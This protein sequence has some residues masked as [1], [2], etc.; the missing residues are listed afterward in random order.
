MSHLKPTKKTGFLDSKDLIKVTL[1]YAGLCLLLFAPALTRP[2]ASPDSISQAYPVYAYNRS[3][4]LDLK[5]LPFWYPHISG[6]T[7]YIE[8]M[9]FN[10][11]FDLFVYLTPSIPLGIGYRAMLFV[12]LSG[13][14][15]YLFLKDTGFG[16]ST[17][18]VLGAAYML[19]GC[20]VTYTTIGH[21]GKVVNMAFLPLAF[22]LLERG[23]RRR[24]FLWFLLA[25]LPM[26]FMFKGHPQI[27]YYNMLIVTAWFAFR[28]LSTA[29]REKSLKPVLLPALGYGLTA[30]AAML[31]AIDNLWG[32]LSF[33]RFT[34]RAAETDPLSRW[35]F[36]TSWSM[37]PWELLGYILPQVFGLKDDTY[38]GWRPFVSTMEYA[39]LPVLFLSVYG[40]LRRWKD[41]LVRF[42]TVTTVLAALH[43]FGS[44]FGPYFRL[45]Y[46]YLPMIKSFR[47]PSSV[48][49]PVTFLLLWLAAFGLQDLLTASEDTAD[50]KKRILYLALAFPLVALLM[51]AFV[52]SGFHTDLLKSNL[53]SRL[54][55]PALVGQYGQ[56]RVDAFINQTA[57]AVKAVAKS[58]L[59]HLW[60]V[61]LAAAG[62]LLLLRSGRLKTAT[63]VTML[64]VLTS[65]DLALIGRK[66]VQTVESYD[67]VSRPD[68]VVRFLQA[69]K[70]E[71][72][73]LIPFPPQIDNEA[74]KWSFF[75]LESAFGY[76]P[77]GLQV[78]DDIQKAGLL[79]D[80]RFLGL[81]N[82]KYLLSRQPL[83]DDPRVTLVHK[84]SKFVYRN[85][86]FL[87]RITWPERVLVIADPKERLAYLRSP[88]F[89]PPKET[90][91]AEHPGIDPP[92]K[93]P[94]PAAE[95]LEWSEDRIRLR[96]S[97][98]VP[99]ILRLS[100]V[101]FPRWEAFVDGQAVKILQADHLF[102]AVVVPAGEHELVLRYRNDG[103]YLPLMIVSL[104][105]GVGLIVLL[106]RHL[107]SS[108][109][110]DDE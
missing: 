107:R 20:S 98:P 12:L 23:L 80:L 95:V 4:F 110:S 84:G 81:F 32:Q 40:V 71:K 50:R 67:M 11:L 22:L 61:S 18:F 25:G 65:A 42:L 97:T 8:G 37:H 16:R 55:I 85:N 60:F 47:V 59:P 10:H 63:F 77:V 31:V 19:S 68:D 94:P 17:A 21:Y 104:V 74:N 44:F 34:S 7:P 52:N 87:P 46:N 105:A 14:L 83:G 89:D 39:G 6:G 93:A 78:Y 100:E 1:L 2:L 72:F 96:V 86:L 45:F 33:V 56:A 24:Q 29:F 102:R 51:T 28:I 90:V 27:F 58:G 101:Y 48:Y 82:V 35:Q 57:M 26:G 36:A 108:P 66:F 49:I 70:S 62:L 91:L 54:D 13:I 106:V 109:D 64:F 41:P 103:T 30:V 53:A 38:L 15:A 3:R 92:T 69:D 76:N 5:P 9:H 73:R 99:R 88:A 79:F 75:G 43:G